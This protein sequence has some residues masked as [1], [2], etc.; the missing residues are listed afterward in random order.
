VVPA[1]A[2]PI[3]APGSRVD[4]VVNADVIV[5]RVLVAETIDEGAQVLVAVPAEHA[6]LVA[7][8]AVTGEVSLISS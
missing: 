2:M 6:A 8:L 5:A 7:T 4:I 1:V 3:L